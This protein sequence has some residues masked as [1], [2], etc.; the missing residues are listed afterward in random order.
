MAKRALLGVKMKLLGL[1]K[2]EIK[3]VEGSTKKVN[4]NKN[5]SVEKKISKLCFPFQQ[6]PPQNSKV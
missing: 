1:K 3:P 5:Y 2:H 6:F 4:K